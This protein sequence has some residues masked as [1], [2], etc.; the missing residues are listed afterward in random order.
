M[1]AHLYI[2][3]LNVGKRK[4][5]QQSLLNDETLKDFDA[6]ATVEPY[7]YKHP[8]TGKPT[9][10]PHPGWQMFTPSREREDGMPRHAFRS[11][12]WVN[13]SC[14]A[15][16]VWVDS[17]DITAVSIQREGGSV[18][19]L[20]A[21]DPR[22][23]GCKGDRET[24]L[25]HKLEL[26]ART[27][28]N[29]KEEAER[30]GVSLEVVIA[31][32]LNRHHVLWGG[33]QA[34]TAQERRHEGNPIVDFIQEQGLQ[35]MLKAG[36]ITWDHQTADMSSTPDTVFASEGVATALIRCVVHA[37]DHGSDHRGIV[38]E[39]SVQLDTYR[40]RERRR[41]YFD[42][43][44]DAIRAA[45]TDRLATGSMDTSLDTSLDTKDHLD[46]AAEELVA[47]VNAIL[48][49]TVPRAKPSPYTKRWW[50]KELSHLRRRLTTMRNHVTTLRRRNQDS[51]HAKML[52]HQ[53][54][55]A[56]F[57]EMDRQKAAHWKEFLDEASN[58]WKANQ[59]VKGQS[60]PVQV[61]TLALEG[62]I[63]QQDKDKANMLMEAFFPVPPT[64]E[65]PPPQ[66]TDRLPRRLKAPHQITMHEVTRAVFASNPKKAAGVDGLTFKVW[67]ELWPVL[68]YR[69]LALYQASYQLAHT[70]KSWRVAKVITLRKPGKPDYTKP[71][72]FRPISLLPT[73]SKGLEAVIAARLSY[74]AEEKGLLPKNHF[75]ARPKRS[76]EQ[77]LNVL[78]ERIHEAWR[79]KR[80]LSLVSFDVQGAFNGVHSSVLYRRL[81]Q[82]RV[83]TQMA[84]WIQD[85][86]QDRQGSIVVGRYESPIQ[87]ICF[88]GI[89]Q[90]SPLSPILYVFYNADLVDMD[91]NKS[92][93]AIG[94]VDDFNAWVTGGSSWE[95]TATI[96]RNIL[97]RVEAWAKESGAIFEADKTGLIHFR[98]APGAPAAAAAGAPDTPDS[99]NAPRAAA[100]HF[101]G[102]EI[103]PQ[104]TV[105]VLGVT[106]DT[107]LRM[108]AHISKVTASA[109]AKCIAL[110]SVKGLR[111][112]QMRQLYKACVIPTMDY[113]ASAWFGPGKRGTERQLNRLGQVQRLGAR[114]ILR[115]FRMVSLE[116]LEAEA[117]LK[118]ARCRLTRKTANHAGKLLAAQ[119]DNPARQAMLIRTRSTR[120]RSPLQHT[121]IAH[122]KR[123][124]PR[125]SDPI[126]LDPAWIH[127]PWEDWSPLV[128]IQDK[129]TATQACK[130]VADNRTPAVYTDASCKNGLS[131]IGVVQYTGPT[132]TQLQCASVGRQ[133]TCSVLAT[134]LAAIRQALRLGQGNYIFS[135]STRALTAIS[136]GNKATS[137]RAILQDISLLLRQRASSTQQLPKL[138][139][140]PGHKG[141]PGNERANT[142]ARQA[143]AEQ[144]HP[145][146]PVD[147]RIQEL[148]GV[149][150]LIERDRSENPTPTRSH[151]HVGHYTWQL[152]QALPGKHALA[153]YNNVS[154]EEASVL[155]QA[156]TGHCRL[157]QS[158][159]RLKVVDTA[160]CQCGEGEESIQHVLLHC[161]RWTAARV[162]LQAAAGDR[163]GDVSYLLGGWGTK[164]H[165]E[166]GEP[167]DGPKERWK[168]DLKVVKHTI[169]FLQ[170]TGRLATSQMA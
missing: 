154:S 80:T 83:P 103:H 114:T 56:Y 140:S 138:A 135:D 52:V 14:K 63:A 110:Q 18:L 78:V 9:V 64:P 46:R 92:G 122:E 7:I 101:Q 151:K 144:G 10:T 1:V 76:A 148:P 137:C 49:E 133:N 11:L 61:P 145:T 164:K 59:F 91:I 86:C 123:L 75:G 25:G 74:L 127:A 97:P 160:D 16:A 89:P 58:V 21:Y 12:I 131:G 69:V 157:N 119:E 118:T 139:W 99:P 38:L 129:A 28:R 141:I 98:R 45:L 29:T 70:P 147:E 41:L 30:G 128:T 94:F 60:T 15:Q 54:R 73:I 158:L 36:T 124:Q 68:Q 136:R 159:Y 90:G 84:A 100:L 87:D 166:T 27:I 102:K 134:E 2:L 162:Q 106:L 65:A 112:M 161:P 96:Q 62:R 155:I 109:L 32:D 67:Q 132:P 31:A 115:A 93:G 152:D 165:W 22:D 43:D 42:A 146:A 71:K 77:A 3:H 150:Q 88:A 53:A 20:S 156:R 50:T 170:H 39:S 5:V 55:R 26:M 51:T 40:E 117:Y 24:Q 121:L 79:G 107:K 72:A 44:W 34:W 8:H 168:P 120:F 153:L 47:T 104:E 66:E 113:A 105:K 143:T 149:L 130:K 85:F 111:P 142:V 169:R 163:W 95:N 33:P 4:Q 108:D 126:T 37:V 81:L 23:G 57:D 125:G 19:I 35:S 167:L 116:V 13:T 48:E 82:R 6:L 17:Y